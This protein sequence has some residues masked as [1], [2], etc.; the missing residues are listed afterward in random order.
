MTT[1]TTRINRNPAAKTESPRLGDRQKVDGELR[2]PFRLQGRTRL[3]IAFH[4][5]RAEMAGLGRRDRPIRRRFEVA[6][7]FTLVEVLV[8]ITLSSFVLTGVLSAFLMLGRSSMNAVNYSVS[9][10]ELRRGIEEFSEDVRM[11][12]AI[13]WNNVT[14]LT[15]TVPDNYTATSNQVTYAYDP[16][17][18]GP[19]AQSFYRVPGTAASSSA[20]TV[21]VH[22]ISTL[23]FARFNRLNG[24]ASTDAATK[25][26]QVTMNVRRASRTVV[27]ANTMLVSASYT[28][29]NKVIN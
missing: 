10:T 6:S 15:L 25:R 28:L 29:R 3:Q 26:I 23:T 21:F 4:R 27:A 2:A 14:S 5:W 24:P 18:S 1:S 8:A 16:S 9:E 13:K 20:K 22:N 17:L 11:A 19:T 12:S 7:A